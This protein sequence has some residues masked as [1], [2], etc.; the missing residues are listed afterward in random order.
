MENLEQPIEQTEQ[1]VDNISVDQSAEVSE[2]PNS[3]LESSEDDDGKDK[4]WRQ[5]RQRMR[6]KN[7]E[8]HSMRQQMGLMA[9]H[10]QELRSTQKKA[11][12]PVDEPWLTET[13]KRL[14]NE[15]NEVKGYV[16]KIRAKESDY[17]IERLRGRFNDFDSVVN[18]DNVKQL[19]RD[20]PALAK[21]IASMQGDQYEQGLAAYEILKRSGYQQDG[22]AMYDKEK[23]EKNTKKPVSVQAVRKEGPLAEAN[24]F[25]MGLT[26]ALQKELNKEMTEASKRS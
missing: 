4:N 13:E 5:A 24:R 1:H 23:L 8:L 25:A 15:L 14:H 3:H 20:N 6:E 10:L 11:P 9:Q 7:E 21:A 19:Q 12:E 16:E 18:V 26:P 22:Q 2:N 17:V